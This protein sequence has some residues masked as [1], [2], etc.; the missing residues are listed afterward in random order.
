MSYHNHFSIRWDYGN[1]CSCGADCDLASNEC[2][3]FV[4]PLAAKADDEWFHACRVHA[5]VAML[6]NDLGG[7]C[8]QESIE[9]REWD[10]SGPN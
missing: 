9:S 6:L 2:S 3:G 5:P 7:W 4:K 1:R 8:D 10:R